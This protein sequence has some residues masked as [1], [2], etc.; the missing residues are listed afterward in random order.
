MHRISSIINVEMITVY[1]MDKP[2]SLH[3]YGEI[4]RRMMGSRKGGMGGYETYLEDM[5]RFKE[6]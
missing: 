3:G 2:L 1:G 5:Y 6:A 4:Y